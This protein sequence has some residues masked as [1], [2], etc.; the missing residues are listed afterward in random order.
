[1]E[2]HITCLLTYGAQD[3]S[4]AVIICGSY[5]KKRFPAL[6]FVFVV[7]FVALVRDLTL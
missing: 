5:A 1:M 3:P 6:A 4:N 2:D 7:I